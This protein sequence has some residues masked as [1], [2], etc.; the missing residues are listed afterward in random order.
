MFQPTNQ[1]TTNS[2]PK[3]SD[4]IR[5]FWASRRSVDEQTF[6]AGHLVRWCLKGLF[7]EHTIRLENPKE[8]SACC[9][10]LSAG[11]LARG[12]MAVGPLEQPLQP[13]E[14][15]IMWCVHFPLCIAAQLCQEGSPQPSEALHVPL[16][17]SAAFPLQPPEDERAQV[18]QEPRFL[19][20]QKAYKLKEHHYSISIMFY[21]SIINTYKYYMKYF[22]TVL[23]LSFF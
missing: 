6:H 15:P 20:R 9:K 22:Y 11:Y 7:E 17:K 19:P 8:V 2:N 1:F 13:S 23:L 5:W 16:G 18:P 12:T 3:S 10:S 4:S 14:V 21:I